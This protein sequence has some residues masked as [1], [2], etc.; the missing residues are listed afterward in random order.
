MWR[1]N[2]GGKTVMLTPLL[3][4]CLMLGSYNDFHSEMQPTTKH[5]REVLTPEQWEQYGRYLQAWSDG[6]YEESY[7]HISQ[8]AATHVPEPNYDIWTESDEEILAASARFS[9]AY[10]ASSLGP[11]YDPRVA[12]RLH[13]LIA[14]REE[15]G[16]STEE[17]RNLAQW[18]GQYKS[19]ETT[20]LLIEL[21]E[22][23]L[24]EELSPEAFGLLLACASGIGR[25]GAPLEGLQYLTRMVTKEYWMERN[26]QPGCPACVSRSQSAADV[27][28]ML[29]IAAFHFIYFSGSLYALE[30]L[31]SGE[32]FPADLLE[33]ITLELAISHVE[34]C[35]QGECP[36]F[37][38]RP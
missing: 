31:Q 13:A 2:C 22:E 10:I 20:A 33:P 12:P 30:V 36:K 27:R 19:S 3:A 34:A 14:R 6:N 32:A 24:P 5:L 16:L 17:L 18:V 28:R 29:R 23:P 38:A 21:L 11:R 37:N 25:E 7:R 8:L 1:V 15:L 9:Q 26:A 4:L 35:L